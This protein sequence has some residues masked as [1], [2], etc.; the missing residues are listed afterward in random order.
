[1]RWKGWSRCLSASRSGITAPA[2]GVR[3]VLV[4]AAATA[5]SPAM[6]AASP[7]GATAMAARRAERAGV[8]AGLTV[9]L[10]VDLGDGRKDRR[11]FAATPAPITAPITA[12][13][14][15][16]ITAPITAPTASPA[17]TAETVLPV[18]SSLTRSEQPPQDRARRILVTQVRA[19]RRCAGRR[20]PA[21]VSNRRFFQ[22]LLPEL[23]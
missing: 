9:A 8:R 6:A 23:T 10:K 2:A 11:S 18:A 3:V 12:P 15:A 22:H 16:R 1:M 19:I 21:D 4:P 17:A 20:H 14:T 5:A 7:A 13:T